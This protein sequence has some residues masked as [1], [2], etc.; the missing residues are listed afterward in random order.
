M[1]YNLSSSLEAKKKQ[2]M[3]MKIDNVIRSQEFNEQ[4]TQDILEK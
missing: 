4:T 2:L 3:Q 1:Q